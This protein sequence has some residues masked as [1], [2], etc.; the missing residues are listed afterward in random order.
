MFSHVLLCPLDFH[1]SSP[2]VSLGHFPSHLSLGCAEGP[3]NLL[4]Q[5]SLNQSYNLSR[6]NVT[7]S[8]R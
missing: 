8:P 1:S 5:S 7:E 3:V 2:L 4:G 6:V